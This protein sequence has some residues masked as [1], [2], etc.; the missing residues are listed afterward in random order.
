MSLLVSIGFI[1]LTEEQQVQIAKA[2][3]SLCALILRFCSHTE[4]AQ[5]L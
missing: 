5:A 4:A 3:T 2:G 1:S